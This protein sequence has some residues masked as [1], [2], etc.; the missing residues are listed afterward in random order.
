MT[1][2]RNQPCPCGSGKKY[3]HC[4]MRRDS[5]I[6][7]DYKIYGGNTESDLREQLGIDGTVPLTEEI[8]DQLSK[9]WDAPDLRK[10]LLSIIPT[11]DHGYKTAYYSEKRGSIFFPDPD[12]KLVCF[13]ITKDKVVMKAIG[14]A[15]DKFARSLIA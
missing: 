6:K 3:K 12:E 15:A 10:R 4:C 9:E 8:I 7:R 2:K 11:C 14:P 13:E 1:S 5:Y